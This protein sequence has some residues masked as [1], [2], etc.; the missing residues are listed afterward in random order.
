MLC[1]LCGFLWHFP[2]E[3]VRNAKL[4]CLALL[5]PSKNGV[6]TH[7][8]SFDPRKWDSCLAFQKQRASAA[9]TTGTE[10]SKGLDF[11]LNMFKDLLKV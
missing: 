5:D 4:F 6:M 2:D 7:T 10:Y 9:Q 1:V 8:F 11:L 3:G